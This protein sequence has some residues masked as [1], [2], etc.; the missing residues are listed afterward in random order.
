MSSVKNRIT[1]THDNRKNFSCRLC[2]GNHGLRHC[3]EFMKKEVNERLRLVISHKYC[4]NCLAHRHSAGSCFSSKGCRD[5]GGSHHSLLHIEKKEGGK[6]QQTTKNIN[7]DKKKKISKSKR[8]KEPLPAP[9]PVLK[10][11]T[12][13]SL[14]AP[15]TINL[16]PT[17]IVLVNNGEKQHHVRA[18]LDPCSSTSKI[19]KQLVTDLALPTTMLGNDS[20]CAITI[21]SRQLPHVSLEAAMLVNNRISIHTPNKSIDASIATKLPNITLA[22]PQFYKS[23]PFAI[24]LA[25]DVYGKIILPGLLPSTGG[26]PVA[27]NTIFGWVLSGSCAV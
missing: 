15:N 21:C 23:G 17:A 22:D 11:L 19:S 4:P 25:S 7:Q 1:K 2:N 5:C 24:I 6:G 9:T 18:I 16:F 14:T 13:T 12:I 8:L 20:I 27:M 3:E 26:L 10:T